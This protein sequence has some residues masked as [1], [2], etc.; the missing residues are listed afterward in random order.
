MSCRAFSTLLPVLLVLAVSALGCNSARDKH[1]E[2]IEAAW[3][4]LEKGALTTPALE[5]DLQALEEF[6]AKYPASH[7]HGN[8]RAARAG[9]LLAQRREQVRLAKEREEK[10]AGLRGKLAPL[11]ARFLFSLAAAAEPRERY[12]DLEPLRVLALDHEGLRLLTRGRLSSSLWEIAREG[13]LAE[14]RKVVGAALYDEKR[15]RYDAQALGVLLDAAYIPPDALLLGK[16]AQEAYLLF[17][18]F[19]RTQARL[20]QVVAHQ[21]EAIRKYEGALARGEAHYPDVNEERPAEQYFW[22]DSSMYFNEPQKDRRHFYQAVTREL[23]LDGKTGLARRQFDPL[24]VGFW[25]RRFEDETAGILGAFLLRVLDG[26]DPAYKKELQALEGK[27]PP[28]EPRGTPSERVRPPLHEG[29]LVADRLIAVDPT[30]RAVAFDEDGQTLSVVTDTDFRRISRADGQVL[31]QKAL[32]QLEPPRPQK[33][34]SATFSQDGSV[35]ALAFYDSDALKDLPVCL[36]DAKT[37]E[38]LELL[39]DVRTLQAVHLNRD[40]SLLAV[41]L[42]SSDI[43]V[44]AIGGAPAEA[45]KEVEGAPD[46]GQDSATPAVARVRTIMKKGR[47]AGLH[48]DSSLLF[49]WADTKVTVWDTE[50]GEARFE[51]RVKK[52]ITSAALSPD[53]STLF[54]G[55]EDGA[56]LVHFDVDE[57]RLS[58]GATLKGLSFPRGVFTQSGELVVVNTTDGATRVLEV[59]KGKFWPGGVQGRRV[60]AISP[61]EELLLMQPPGEG[62]EVLLYA[63]GAPNAFK[64]EFEDAKAMRVLYG[65]FDEKENVSS[66]KPTPEEEARLKKLEGFSAP[67]FRALPWKTTTYSVG[68]EEKVLFLTETRSEPISHPAT[69]LIGGAIFTRSRTGWEVEKRQ[70]VI[71]EIGSFGAAPDSTVTP[72]EIDGKGFLAG[73]TTGYTGMGTTMS[74]LV[75]LSDVPKSV[76]KDVIAEVGH[77]Q[78]TGETNEGNC[79]DADEDG[80]DCY[81]YDSVWELDTDTGRANSELPDLVLTVSGTR[82]NSK[83]NQVQSFHEERRY[84]FR[85]GEY[86]Q[87]R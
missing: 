65:S 3:A 8:P 10:I 2:Q 42:P 84:S 6:L 58:P 79:A 52:R 77:I 23:G 40:G 46:A 18:P 13:P 39:E 71:T 64:G 15:H 81:A 17:R 5:D 49:A 33:L 24:D 32:P 45:E 4:A 22:N 70:R 86:R 37:G 74:S 73:L 51:Q 87:K 27:W 35:L 50:G 82:M 63:I 7:E 25:L 28:M 76:Q 69:A 31:L 14:L 68:G 1:H 29:P 56:S 36:L 41:E 38:R 12:G 61:D 19:V 85:N 11:A 75:F 53:G 34:S 80:P 72:Y 16:T 9:E 66:W 20:Y 47:L 83:R 67:N 30:W 54:L 26:Y 44:R 59:S 55:H 62:G 78:D 21:R 57:G 43:V 60:L 48:P